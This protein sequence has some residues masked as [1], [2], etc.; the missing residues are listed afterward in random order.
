MLKLSESYQRFLC[1]PSMS[2]FTRRLPLRCLLRLF[3]Y[4]GHGDIVMNWWICYV[5]LCR[6]IDIGFC[7]SFSKNEDNYENIIRL[8]LHRAAA[9]LRI[10]GVAWFHEIALSINN[11][12]TWMRLNSKAWTKFHIIGIILAALVRE[13]WASFASK[14]V[15]YSGTPSADSNRLGNC[16]LFHCISKDCCIHLNDKAVHFKKSIYHCDIRHLAHILRLFTN[17]F[18]RIKK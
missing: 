12:L 18:V 10:V 2:I 17:Y 7:Y 1:C 9:L 15:Q 4:H 13:P 14:F 8:F 3:G 16:F 11:L 6:S 5:S